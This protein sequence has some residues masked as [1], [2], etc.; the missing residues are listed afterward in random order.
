MTVCRNI[1]IVKLIK[2]LFLMFDTICID[3]WRLQFLKFFSMKV[4][5]FIN[6][7]TLSLS[8]NLTLSRICGYYS[9]RN[10]FENLI[11]PSSRQRTMNSGRSARLPS[12][13]SRSARPPCLP[14]R[15]ARPP[16]LPSR[17]A[18]LPSLKPNLT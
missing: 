17:S 6:I 2:N 14:S 15:S 1:F 18:R 3:N 10:F 9:L 11:T 4:T 8:C 12:L 7:K 5:K 13:P 16:C